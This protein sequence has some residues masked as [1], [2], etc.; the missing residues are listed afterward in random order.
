[1]P[2]K[3]VFDWR[4]NSLG[5]WVQDEVDKLKTAGTEDLTYGGIGYDE[6]SIGTA[7]STYAH[8]KQQRKYDFI[9]EYEYKINSLPQLIRILYFP[10]KPGDVVNV[11]V[12][13][14]AEHIDTVYQLVPAE[15]NEYQ[16]ALDDAIECTKLIL[17]IP[18][19]GY[20]LL[21]QI[22]YALR[23]NQAFGRMSAL[24]ESVIQLQ[25]E[26]ATAVLS[27]NSPDP[28]TRSNQ[29]D[30]KYIT[31]ISELQETLGYALESIATLQ[32][33]IDGQE[34]TD[35]RSTTKEINRH[36]VYKQL[37]DHCQY[38]YS[39]TKAKFVSAREIA[40]SS[41]SCM[42]QY[43]QTFSGSVAN[44]SHSMVNTADLNFRYAYTQS[45][46]NFNLIKQNA[47][48]KYSAAILNTT[49]FLANSLQS[50][51]ISRFNALI[52]LLIMSLLIV[53]IAEKLDM[54]RLEDLKSPN[55]LFTPGYAA[56][57][58]TIASGYLL[59]Y[60]HNKAPYKDNQSDQLAKITYRKKQKGNSTK[61]LY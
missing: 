60:A 13:W 16:A 30:I 61:N 19:S 43:S 1:M 10:I 42:W 48:S 22:V 59:Y 38:F 15:L 57:C 12:L 34:K 21:T 5:L 44:I 35:V 37:L 24:E 32:Q 14:S 26:L 29:D 6:I 23:F 3:L 45:A 36:S 58:M 11:G 4:P 53:L 27:I 8:A 25:S 56:T 2:S 49:Q 40:S 9:C 28:N 20:S 51:R 54:H 41:S 17:F 31:Q 55:D 39:A 47:S 50:E 46:V 18:H 52:D 7:I 33:R